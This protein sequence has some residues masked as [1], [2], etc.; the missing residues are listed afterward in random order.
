LAIGNPLLDISAHVDVEYLKKY[1]LQTGNAI[2]AEP[3]HLPIYEEFAKKPDVTYIPGG[4][5]QN[6][7]RVAQ[8]LI[9]TPRATGY[10]GC[11]GKDENGKTLQSALEKVGVATHYLVEEKEPTGV[12]AVLIVDKERSLCT[13]LGAANH[14]KLSHYESAEIQKVV[15]SAQ[16]YYSSGYFLTV[17]TESVVALGKHAAEKNKPFL[18][19][20][21]APFII[22]FFR[23]QLDSV[24]PYTDVIFCNEGEAQVLGEAFQ[25]GKDLKV[26]AQ[27]LAELPKVN[28][29]RSRV[30]VFTHGA[31]ATIVFH[32]GK[33]TEFKVPKVPSEEIIDL[34]GAG[35]AFCGGFL[36][37]FVQGK[38][39]EQ[40]VAAGHYAAGEVIRRSGCTYPE[41]AN[42]QFK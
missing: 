18:F 34:N 3:K 5:A 14:Y 15:D 8:W 12:C 26:V 22:Q 24:L 10:I 37:G 21:A 20:L 16:V 13:N 28:S 6:A 11:I 40:N 32:D 19:N 29:K 36:A 31:D 27:K 30:V 23:S 2:L 1:D 17:S 35:D 25:W 39:L 33:L 41:K 38:D 42:F 7:I 9:G 4:D